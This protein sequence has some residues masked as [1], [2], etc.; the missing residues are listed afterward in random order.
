MTPSIPD[1]IARTLERMRDS[2]ASIRFADLKRVCDFHFG[3]A[4]QRGTSHLVDKMPWAGDP[5]VNIQNAGGLAKSY[6]VRQV[7]LAVERLMRDRS[8][9]Q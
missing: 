5:R 1:T 6:Q 4:R 8:S 7:R 9:A 2:P 3:A